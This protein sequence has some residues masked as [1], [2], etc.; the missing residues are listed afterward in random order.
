VD[1]NYGV[2]DGVHIGATWQIQMKPPVC[3]GDADLCQ[4]T[5][6]TVM[7]AHGF[8]LLLLL[9]IAL[10]IF[11]PCGFFFFLFPR[12]FSAVRDWLSTMLPHNDVALVRI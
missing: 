1:A 5:V 11:Y 4:I 9:M 7:A 8:Y 12:L 3:G 10:R 2:P 6:T